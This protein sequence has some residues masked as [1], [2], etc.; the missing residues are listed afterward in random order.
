[1][2]VQRT[3]KYTNDE[4]QNCKPETSIMLLT[5]DTPINKL[6]EKGEGKMIGGGIKG[7]HVSVRLNNCWNWSIKGHVQKDKSWSKNDMPKTEYRGI[8][9]TINNKSSVM[10]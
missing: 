7:V 9:L 10:A 6:K 1:M 5:S 4:L 2:G 3:T 8:S